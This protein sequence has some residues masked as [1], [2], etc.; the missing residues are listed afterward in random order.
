MQRNKIQRMAMY[1]PNPYSAVLDDPM[2]QSNF[3]LKWR[4]IRQD[5]SMRISVDPL[6]VVQQ[7]CTLLVSRNDL[8]LTSEAE[9]LSEDTWDGDQQG[10]D[11]KNSH[12]DEGEDPLESNG[13]CEE[14]SNS[15]R[16]GQD[17]QSKAHSVVLL[18]LVSPDQGN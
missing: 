13:L 12:D 16:S 15:E 18:P 14:L 6:V 8:T 9:L 1:P 17:A 11:E 2:F 5:E 7:R 10:S 4:G 3:H